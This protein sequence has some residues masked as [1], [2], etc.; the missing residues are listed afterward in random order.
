MRP[1]HSRGGPLT[2]DRPTAENP[3]EKF[4]GHGTPVPRQRTAGAPELHA[5][6]YS[7]VVTARTGRLSSQVIVTHCPF[8]C[9]SSHRFTGTPLFVVG[10]R[11]A[12]CTGLPF[13]LHALAQQEAA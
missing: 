9:G 12:P 1:G 10:T 13:L 8:R 7:Y 2:T 6:G 11:K 4:T 3:G 5:F